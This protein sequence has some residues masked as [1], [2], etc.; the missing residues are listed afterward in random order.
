MKACVSSLWWDVELVDVPSADV[1]TGDVPLRQA[2]KRSTPP[3][4]RTADFTR[5][6]VEKRAMKTRFM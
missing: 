6:E 3:T 5:V 4:A 2:L 1:E